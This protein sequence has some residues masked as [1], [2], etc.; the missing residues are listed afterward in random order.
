M[1][2]ELPANPDLLEQRIGRIDRIGQGDEIFLHVP[3]IEGSAQEILYRWYYDGLGALQAPC[4]AAPKVY[5]TVK[6]ELEFLFKDASGLSGFIEQTK[7]L[8][9]TINEEL[10]DGRDKL[11]ELNSFKQDVADRL[12]KQLVD[13]EDNH[14]LRDYMLNVFDCFGVDQE[15]HSTLTYILHVG[16]FHVRTFPMPA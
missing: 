12:I 6:E 15:D 4:P 8:T 11:L 10:H 16:R 9:A 3:Y 1:L 5:R 7:K 2:F 13:E 14:R